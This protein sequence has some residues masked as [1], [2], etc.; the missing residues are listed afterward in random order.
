[1]SNIKERLLGAITV[2]T[3]ADAYNLWLYIENQHKEKNLDDIEE[4]EPDEVDL[5]MLD[6]YENDTD[7]EK[8]ETY[9][10]EDCKKEWGID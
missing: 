2:M 10:L 6:E 5:K 1:M 9:S 7:P 3:E 4:V 8:D